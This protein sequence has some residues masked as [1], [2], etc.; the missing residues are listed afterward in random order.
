MIYSP[1]CQAQ[2]GFFVSCFA[3]RMVGMNFEMR[4]W[5][6]CFRS[7]LKSSGIIFGVALGFGALISVFEMASSGFDV[8]RIA[9]ML[10]LMVIIAIVV[11]IFITMLATFA[12]NGNVKLYKALNDYGFGPYYR[13]VYEQ[14][15]MIGRDPSPMEQLGYAE[16]LEKGGFP[17]D[18]LS[19]LSTLVIPEDQP[20]LIA[21]YLFIYAESAVRIGQPQL[22]DMML[23]DRSAQVTSLLQS[24]SGDSVKMF[25]SMAVCMTHCA[26]GRFSL[27]LP[28]ADQTL[29]YKSDKVEM[30]DAKITRLYILHMLGMTAEA[31]ALAEE[32]V[33][34]LD[35][36]KVFLL[37]WQKAKLI[38]EYNMAINGILPM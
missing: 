6:M 8:V 21:L 30:L 11:L 33:K 36:T 14:Q 34:E 24:G 3:E 2:E 16:V 20:A 26:C 25:V 32:I 7:M 35:R 31:S 1:S 19:Y 17:Q 12:Y 38:E 9:D 18:A 5:L 4:Y 22:A 27:A 37:D 10:V 23:S 28:M 29:G 13:Q 15:R